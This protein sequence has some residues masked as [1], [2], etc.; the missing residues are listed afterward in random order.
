VG[1]LS[2]LAKPVYVESMDETRYDRIGQLR[3]Q[4]DDTLKRADRIRDQL[5]DA[6]RDAFP[7][8]HGQP[9]KRGVLAEVVRRSGYSREHVAQLRDGKDG[10]S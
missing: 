4:M 10:N 6:I 7:E 1:W 5:H 9:P 8:T 2:D 3:A